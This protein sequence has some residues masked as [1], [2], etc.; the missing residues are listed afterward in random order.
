MPVKNCTGLGLTPPRLARGLSLGPYQELDPS[1]LAPLRGPP[2]ACRATKTPI[3]P[4]IRSKGH[5]LRPPQY[6]QSEKN[7]PHRIRPK[8]A[9]PQDDPPHRPWL[10]LGLWYRFAQ[11]TRNHSAE[12]AVKIATRSFPPPH[13]T[14]RDG[15]YR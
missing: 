12:R 1:S 9:A 11:V 2:Y 3:R 15:H 6:L 8:K 7:D 4:A 5:R 10:G 13:S 14:H